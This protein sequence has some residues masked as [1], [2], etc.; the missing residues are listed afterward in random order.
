MPFQGPLRQQLGP[1]LQLVESVWIVKLW[2]QQL[3]S[4]QVSVGTFSSSSSVLLCELHSLTTSWVRFADDKHKLELCKRKFPH[5]DGEGSPVSVHPAVEL[6]TNT[7]RC[8]SLASS[9][10]SITTKLGGT[11]PEATQIAATPKTI[12][13][14]MRAM[15]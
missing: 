10:L 7:Q 14:N 15:A 12:G 13:P 5:P 6:P 8:A 1:A 2:L 4:S 3:M 9:H 11:A